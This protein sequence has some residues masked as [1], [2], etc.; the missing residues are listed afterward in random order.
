MLLLSGRLHFQ[1]CH[2]LFATNASELQRWQRRCD[3]LRQL[4]C[5]IKFDP[6][7]NFVVRDKT[8]ALPLAAVSPPSCKPSQ[9]ELEYL[10]GFFD[11]DGCVTMQQDRGSIALQVSQNLDSAEVLVRFRDVFGGGI[12]HLRHATGTSKAALQWM[13]CGTTMQHAALL[14]GSLPSMK[15]EQLQIAARGIVAKADRIKAAQK[16][17]L[18]KQKDHEPARF[19]CSWPYFAGFFDA[20]GSISID[21]LSVGIQLKVGQMNPFVLQELKEFLHRHNL[22]RWRVNQHLQNLPM[23]Q[24]S[25]LATCKMTLQH[26]LDH[27]LNIKQ[28]QASLAL[29]LTAENHLEVRDAIFCLNGLQ[30]QYQRLDDKGIAR[31][32]EISKVSEQLRNASSQHK[33]DLLQR[34]V[35]ELRNEHI[36]QKLIA[37]CHRLRSGIR[38]SLREGGLVS[39]GIDRAAEG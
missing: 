28:K 17:Q 3:R 32:K 6:V 20:E 26:L 22:N 4:Q 31:A 8:F 14:L 12:Y 13:V 7:E 35:E 19:Q 38:Q 11:G 29:S 10:V 15:H 39:S 34:K 18:L 37:K 33:H 36:L 23:L 5:R 9:D 24:C 2:R 21:G 25:H 16:L 30:N 1:L 27:G